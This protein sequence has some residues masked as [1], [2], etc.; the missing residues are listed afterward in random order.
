M[1]SR[2][3]LRNYISILDFEYLDQLGISYALF[4]HPIQA[5]SIDSSCKQKFS[6]HFTV[7]VENV[8]LVKEKG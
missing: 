5:R 6:L 3:G 7:T 2:I 1:F 4:V 8:K